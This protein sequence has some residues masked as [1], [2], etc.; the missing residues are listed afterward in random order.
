MSS[1]SHHPVT[2]IEDALFVT[3]LKTADRLAQ[4]AEQIIKPSG[5][6][7]TQYN[8]LRILRGAGP[9]GLPCRVIGDRMISR[10][11]DMTRL[12]DRL[13]KQGCITRERQTDDRRVIK[14][15]IT[16][17]GLKQLKKLDQPV[18]ELHQSQFRHM[19]GAKLNQ[20]ADLLDELAKRESD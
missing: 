1:R 2:P 5:L 18:H 4:Q 3:I 8:V 20:L 7:A 11:P 13:E 19:S 15:R 10:D 17:E 12:L 9:E 14:T 6:T 16:A